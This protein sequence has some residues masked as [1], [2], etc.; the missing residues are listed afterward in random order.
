MYQSNYR[1]GWLCLI[2]TL[3]PITSQLAIAVQLSF[4][5]PSV[6]GESVRVQSGESNLTAVCFLGAQ[7]PMARSYAATLNRLQN[8]YAKNGVRIVGVFSNSQDSIE[9]V[10]RYANEL[11]V[12]F[13]VVHD[14]QNDI[15]DR[16]AATRTPEVF[17]LDRELKLRYHGRIDDRLSP[18]V[19]RQSATREDLRIAI[20]EFLAG[21]PVSVIDTVALGCLIGRVPRSTPATAL[22]P[23]SPTYARDIAPMLQR[24]CVE[25]HRQDEIGPFAMESYGDVVGWAETMLETMDNGRMPPWHAAPGPVEILDARRMPPEDKELFR[26]WLEAGAPEGDPADLPPPREYVAGWQL[27]REPDK[28]V[29][30]RSHPFRVPADG[31]VEYQYFVAELD[32]DED[33]WIS[34]AEVIPGRRNVVHHAIAFV[35]PPD[36]ADFS[37]IGWL[38]AYVPGQR[39]VPLPTGYA[40]RVPAGSKLVFQMHYTPNG[41]E[42]LDT[43]K[44]G[45]LFADPKS[46]THEVFTLMAIDQEFEIPPGAEHT[47]HA[48]LPW[49]PEDG[50]VLAVTPHMHFRGKSFKLFS[51]AFRDMPLLSVPNYDFNWQHT[52]AFA[53]ALPAQELKELKF[54]AV[55]DNSANNPFNPAPDEWVTWGDQTWEEMA[56]AF[57]AV[58]RPLASGSGGGGGRLTRAEAD[59]NDIRVSENAAKIDDYVAKVLAQLDANGDGLVRHGETGILLRRWTFNRW[60]KNGDDVITRDEI[61]QV[62]ESLYP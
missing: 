5:L 10:Q 24:N 23:D 60:D 61:Q 22:P 48:R 55:F 17:L 39:V 58:A 3:C 36:G 2:A 20:D 32:F 30:M 46:V 28:V 45:L 42:Q 15:A 47:V 56:V 41:M 37:G 1:V 43:T 38:S 54:E 34:A 27:P 51:D 44:I 4:E 9:D 6:G 35:R 18:G 53:R 40:R 29:N 49:L 31:T 26:R 59:T 21:K 7:C 8:K 50:E 19:T 62:A 12:E 52:Y 16:Y 13:S 25:C 11:R 14:A 57:F 33:M